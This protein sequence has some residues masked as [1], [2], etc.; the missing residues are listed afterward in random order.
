MLCDFRH[1]QIDDLILVCETAP[2]GSRKKGF[3]HD[4]D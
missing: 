1:M 2:Q 3:G 4:Q